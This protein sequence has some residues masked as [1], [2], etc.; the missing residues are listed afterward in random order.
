MPRRSSSGRCQQREAPRV[1]RLAPTLLTM[2]AVEGR[3]ESASRMSSFTMSGPLVLR[4]CRCLRQHVGRPAR[5]PQWFIA[6]PWRPETIGL[7]KSHGDVADWGVTETVP[8]EPPP[9]RPRRFVVIG[10]REREAGGEH[11]VDGTS[12]RRCRTG[13]SRAELT[14]QRHPAD[15]LCARCMMRAKPARCASTDV[16]TCVQPR[17]DLVA[18]RMGRARS[19]RQARPVHSAAMIASCGPSLRRL[20][21][22]PSSPT[23]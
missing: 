22:T 20:V 10:A 18:L 13:P 16:A 6:I 9:R 5:T 4:R 23:A 8:S 15:R 21:G 7:G 14:R 19:K 1:S 12:G 3:G 2:T 11:D 17:V